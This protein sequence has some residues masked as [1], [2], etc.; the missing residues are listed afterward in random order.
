[1]HS[2]PFAHRRL[3]LG[4]IL[5]ASLLALSLVLSA[6]GGSSHAK[7]SGPP[8]PLVSVPNTGGDL[9]QNF[10][11]FDTSVSSYGAQG[12][13]YE[14]LLFFNRADGSIKPWL[15]QSYSYSSD[16]T[17]VTFALRQGVQWTDGTPFTADDVAFT[18]NLIKQYP[19]IDNNGIGSAIKQVT[20]TDPQ[21][22]V[23]TLAK[24]SSSLL[25]FV[26]G[27]TWIVP[28]HIWATVGDPSKYDNSTPVGTGPFVFKSFTPQ[29][30]VLSKNPH[31]WQPGKPV[32]PEM[33]YP[34]FNSN[35]SAE[36]AMNTD[37]TDWNGLYVPDVAKTFVARDPQ[38]NHYYFAPSDPVM[39]LLNLKKAPFDQLTV[40]KAISLAI[41]RNQL[42]KVG[43][44]GY[45]PPAHP[46]GLVLPSAQNFLD[47]TYASA[48]FTTDA[49]QATQLL[50]DAGFKKG[51]DGILLGADGKKLSFKLHVVSGWTDW[52]S[53]C[54]IMVND[55]KAIGIEV[56]ITQDEFDSFYQ[57]L[58]NGAF[59]MAMW[60]QTPGPT[61]YYVYYEALASANGAP[62]GQAANTNFE[63]WNDPT[64]DQL[65]AQFDESIDPAV[66]KQA[67]T[68]LE[69]IVVD[70]LPVIFLMNEPYWYEYNTVKYVGWPDK[71][72]MYAEPAPYAYPDNEI[73]ALN[74]QQ[75]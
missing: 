50:T 6:C 60:G 12:M 58:Q 18:F 23:V 34:A 22:A 25:W 17:Q 49:T 45:E 67:I 66:Q 14:T 73:I 53:D 26:A 39:L 32:V 55:L 24:A 3:K 68:G 27:Q 65:L 43:E 56:T 4:T 28:K 20:A 7:K 72:N 16:G 1:M 57:N 46:T 13:I 41:D 74:L 47:P 42:W 36:L 9:V 10:N 37:Q 38:R 33:R 69:K 48:A 19:A 75:S 30:I 11:P 31:F 35:T 21:T 2:R 61:P 59:D 51:S 63:R 15:A 62:I 64:T 44:S 8:Q 29:L 54:Q 70:Q 52:I 5:L 40:R 71:G